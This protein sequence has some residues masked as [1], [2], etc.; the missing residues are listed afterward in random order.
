[1]P[2]VL[3]PLHRGGEGEPLVVLHGFTGTWHVWRPVMGALEERFDVLAPTLCGHCGAEGLPAGAETSIGAM[4]DSLE[5]QLDE[6][7]IETAHIAGNSLGGWLALELARR[8]RAR[9]VVALAPAGGWWDDRNE[10]KRLTRYFHRLHRMVSVAAPRAR[11]LVS[12]PGL[13]KLMFRDVMVHGDR[14]PPA[15][16]ARTL[17]G[18][19]GCSIFFDFLD[20]VER[21]GPAVGFDEV[22]CPVLIAWPDHDKIFPPPKYAARYQSAVPG[23]ALVE[24]PECGHVPMYDDPELVARTIADFAARAAASQP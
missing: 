22:K 1:M 12:R 7:G 11:G 4:A 18:I 23:S 5:A 3:E 2:P 10:E 8:G 6:A 19:V 14:M 24:L 20:A 21:D 15:D 16:A 9:S 17:D 13:R